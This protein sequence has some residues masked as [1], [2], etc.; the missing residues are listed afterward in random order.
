MITHII[1]KQFFC[2]TDV[3]AIGKFIPRKLLCV[4]HAFTESTLWRR[5]N[6]TKE[7]LAGSAVQQMSCAIGH[8]F[9]PKI[10][11]CVIILGPIVQ[12]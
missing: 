7:F 12:I 6:Y 5:P 8:E 11:V 10:N 3:R 9:P 4:L 1:Q 2:V